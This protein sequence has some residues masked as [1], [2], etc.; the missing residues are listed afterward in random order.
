MRALVLSV[1]GVLAIATA[2]AV[3]QNVSNHLAVTA[4]NATVRAT[5]GVIRSEIDILI[6]A[7][8]LTD[9]STARAAA[10]NQKLERLVATGHL[11]RIKIWSLDGTVVYSDWPSIRG[12]QFELTD[13]LTSVFA[14][15]I[16]TEFEA[17]GHE[18]EN[19]SETDLAD[20]L[21]SIYLPIR[22]PSGD[23]VAAYEIYE[24]AA[25]IEASIEATRRDVLGIVGA[26]GLGLLVLLFAAFSG[27]SRRLT[28]QNRQLIAQASTEQALT[29]DLR[30]SQER[31]RSLVRNSADVNMILGSDGRIQY[32]SQA[33]ERVLGYRS[34]ERVGQSAF[35]LIHP[36]D[37]ERAQLLMADVLRTPGAQ[38]QGE[39]RIHHADGS[40]RTIEV[41]GKNLLDDPAVGGLVIN[42]R[43]VTMRKELEDELR[44]QAF[45]D[46]LT[47]LAN[48]ALFADR[49]GHAMTRTRDQ[50]L[51]LAVLF[52]DLDDF[53]SINDSLGHAEGDQLLVAVAERF[54]G[55]LRA[56]DSIARMGGDEFAILL[57]DSPDSSTP[58]QVAERLLSTLQ[59]PFERH[60]KELFV[61][62]SV[63]VAIWT[64]ANQTSDDL[65]RNADVAMYTAKARGKDRIEVFEASMHAA[66]VA[67]FA[68][69]GDLERALKRGELSL[70]YQPVV[71]LDNQAIVGVEALLRWNHPE[72]GAIVPDEFIPIAEE[73]GVIVPIGRWVLEE[74][75]RQV[76]AWDRVRS[77]PPLVINVNVS[78]RQLTERGFVDDVGRILATTGL[79]PARLVLELTEGVL[80]QDTDA[81][82]ATFVALKRL[83]I[84][85][86]IDDFGTGYSSL[87][88]LHRFPIDV[89]KID[90]SFVASMLDGPDQAALLRSI[91]KL[92]ETL[93][94]ETVAEG[95]E[96]A[97][98]LAE[99]QACGATL[100][101]GF[102]FARPLTPEAIEALLTA[103]EQSIGGR[104]NGRKPGAA[105]GTRTTSRARSALPASS[106]APPA[107]G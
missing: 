71:R 41:T 88:Y 103:G 9:P 7:N 93:H 75:C 37:I 89:L 81:T 62:A 59:A 63:G 35:E 51:P 11:L 17:G 101:Q 49:L 78:A 68:L 43:D 48:R 95:V 13:E 92:S 31:Y 77:A 12:R 24:D 76:Q 29:D 14:G 90:R 74:A 107:G 94:L 66:A 86:A 96:D 2:L 19:G 45:H 26:M 33:V 61:H 84:R 20:R 36:D 91:L 32:E 30:R 4:I 28:L 6:S 21:L 83:G 65:L 82:L 69:R 56:A 38:S 46:S 5:E 27:T 97:A 16:A 44:H 53:K 106:T 8:A 85:L 10:I 42:Y 3:S 58:L 52:V 39:L 100:G 104:Q 47:G 64:S 25:P 54:R 57:E 79:D 102:L 60:G 80:M 99:L 34:D 1:S 15:Q 87:S 50:R 98:Q 40:W 70:R 67:R 105:P 18:A 23:V 22:A 72:R 55:A 73:T